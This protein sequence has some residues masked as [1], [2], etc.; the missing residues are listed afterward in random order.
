MLS[1]FTTLR[2]VLTHQKKASRPKE[3][4]PWTGGRWEL[5]Y[6]ESCAVVLL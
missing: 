1:L 4:S 6:G 3:A 2:A 5:L